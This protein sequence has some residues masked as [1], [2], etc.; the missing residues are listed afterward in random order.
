MFAEKGAGPLAFDPIYV[1]KPWGGR[2]LARFG[3][4]L[5]EGPIGESWEIS[6]YPGRISGRTDGPGL[7]ELLADHGPS[8]LG[9]TPVPGEPFPLLFK[10]LD[11]AE[12]LS[13]Q[14]HPSA[15]G[16]DEGAPKDEAWIVLDAEPGAV[17]Y[18]GLV[19]QASADEVRSRAEDGSLPEIL[20]TVE[21]VAGD[22]YH[23]RPGTIHAIGAG[24]LLAEIQQVSDT[25]YRLFDWGRTDA[26]GRSRELHL[27]Q[28]LACACLEADPPEGLRAR[29]RTIEPAIERLVEGPSFTIDR[30]RPG[31]GEAIVHRGGRFRILT[32]VAGTGE[33]RWSGGVAPIEAG[34]TLL[35]PAAL[36][37]TAIA[38]LSGALIL[39][40]FVA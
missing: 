4:V 17:L 19:R 32:A 25:T 39:L 3:R 36:G 18:L 29:P 11:A 20:R 15:P 7:D 8:L 27:D 6:G 12:D 30:I 28:A 23:V 22:C 1:P 24:V 13:V 21:A 35:L 26:A 16:P 9:R 37:E 31:G 38:D 14:V 33:V 10:Y 40:S 5:P 34:T 2:R